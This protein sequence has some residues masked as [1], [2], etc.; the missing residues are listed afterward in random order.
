[1]TIQGLFLDGEEGS[2]NILKLFHTNRY[3]KTA[4]IWFGATDSTKIN[5]AGHKIRTLLSLINVGLQIN[6]GSRKNIKT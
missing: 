2:G 5:C 4:I 3:D 6:V 1:M